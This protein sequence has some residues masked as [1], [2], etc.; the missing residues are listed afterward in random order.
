MKRIPVTQPTKQ[1]KALK[2][3]PSA[4]FTSALYRSGA[5]A[6][7]DQRGRYSKRERASHRAD[8]RRARLESLG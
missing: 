8:E 3:L 4:L 5:G 1:L 7:A 2:H 6:H